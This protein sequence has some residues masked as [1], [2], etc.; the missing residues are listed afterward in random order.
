LGH[1]RTV[2]G[3]VLEAMRKSRRP[4]SKTPNGRRR[5]RPL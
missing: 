5:A 4:P 2:A 1:R 3:I